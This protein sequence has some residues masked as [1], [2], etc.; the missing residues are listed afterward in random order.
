MGQDIIYE[1]RQEVFAHI[2]KLSMRF[3][4]LTPVGKIVT[5]VTNDVESLNEMYSNILKLFKTQ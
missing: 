4:D 2:Q 3:F 1:V 5:R